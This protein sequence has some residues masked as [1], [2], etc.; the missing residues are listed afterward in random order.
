EPS[1]NLLQPIEDLLLARRERRRLHGNREGRFRL[2]LGRLR[3]GPPRPGRGLGLLALRR[4]LGLRGDRAEFLEDLLGLLL[5]DE[6]RV[7]VRLRGRALL[8]GEAG[9]CH[10][11]RGLLRDPAVPQRLNRR[12]SGHRHSSDGGSSSSTSTSSSEIS[13][14]MSFSEEEVEVEEE[15]PP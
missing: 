6:L 8:Q 15:E 9:V 14:Y 3:R 1:S 11:F 5:R 2:R 12:R 7:A 10:D 4:R 13:T